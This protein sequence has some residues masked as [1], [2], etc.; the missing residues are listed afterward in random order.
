MVDELIVVE[1]INE[2]WELA[3]RLWEFGQ[4][5][6]KIVTYVVL[7]VM[8]SHYEEPKFFLQG[9]FLADLL[10]HVVASFTERGRMTR[11]VVE[12]V[13]Y[14]GLG[15]WV[16]GDATTLPSE[17]EQFAMVVLAFMCFGVVKVVLENRRRSNSTTP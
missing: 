8:C 7:L 17:P 3:G 15:V 5:A 6:L 4:V 9:Y 13:L 1:S 10:A 14:V 16:F 11:A 2:T 12:L